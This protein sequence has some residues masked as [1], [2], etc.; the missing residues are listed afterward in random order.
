M[1]NDCQ[2][3]GSNRRV[4]GLVTESWLSNYRGLLL[5]AKARKVVKSAARIQRGD[6]TC[7]GSNGAAQLSRGLDKLCINAIRTLA[8]DAVQQA[9]S[10]HPGTPMALASVVYTI[11][12][13]FLRFDPDDPIWPNRDWFVLS[14]GHA[15]MLLY[16]RLHFTGVK[17]VN[18]KYERFRPPQNG[19]RVTARESLFAPC[20]SLQ[21]PVKF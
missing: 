19:H 3:S 6:P 18:A 21:D 5:A 10:G 7:F 12:Q 9:A 1:R 2:C 8:M 20:D 14:N 15:S 11:W 16:A 13:D 4:F 17:S